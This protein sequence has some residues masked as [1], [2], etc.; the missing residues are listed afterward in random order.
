[1]IACPR[2]GSI[3]GTLEDSIHGRTAHLLCGSTV[4]W[5]SDGTY[6]NFVCIRKGEKKVAQDYRVG[7]E[8][9]V[10]ATVREYREDREVYSS[11]FIDVP[12]TYIEVRERDIREVIE[13]PVLPKDRARYGNNEFTVVCVDGD[14][15]WLK[16]DI[17]VRFSVKANEV[18]IQKTSDA[19]FRVCDVVLVEASVEE[20]LPT[21]LRVVIGGRRVTI[22]QNLI[23]GV[24]SRAIQVQPGNVILHDGEM[25]NVIAVDGEFLWCR[26]PPQQ[27]AG[28]MTMHTYRTIEAS[29]AELISD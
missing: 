10:K 8:V 6:E 1:M 11:Y 9:L 7:D 14:D 28:V 23:R 13:R 24:L 2:C 17:G 21:E 25:Y 15:L 4:A 19:K 26:R 27:L 12:G 3:G 22:S 16:S 29:Q 20:V 18:V 5:R